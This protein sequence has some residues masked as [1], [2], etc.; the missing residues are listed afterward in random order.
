MLVSENF[1][2]RGLQEGNYQQLRT[3][4]DVTLEAATAVRQERSRRVP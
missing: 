1:Y 2:W 3:L 4:P